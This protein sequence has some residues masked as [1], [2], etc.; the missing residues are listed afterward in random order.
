MTPAPT[1][2]TL[3]PEAVDAVLVRVLGAD[4]V[5]ALSPA[6]RSEVDAYVRQIVT[7][8]RHAASVP[9]V[10]VP[11]DWISTRSRLGAKVAAFPILP[12]ACL[13][14]TAAGGFLDRAALLRT[15]LVSAY[16]D[17]LGVGRRPMVPVG[18]PS[19]GRHYRAPEETVEA[20]TSDGVSWARDRDAV[21][22]LAAL[23]GNTG[24]TKIRGGKGTADVSILFPAEE[25]AVEVGTLLAAPV[26]PLPSGEFRVSL[27]GY[28]ARH[29]LFTVNPDVPDRASEI[30]AAL[31]TATP[32]RAPQE[33]TTRSRRRVLGKAAPRS[34]AAR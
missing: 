34:L 10:V 23:V 31:S 2:S 3:S 32:R 30:R 17:A 4:E 8:C 25:D 5:A 13:A 29:L 20:S 28:R 12:P 7:A 19:S 9:G 27:S 6:A 14:P 1:P 16:V 18:P 15:A 21:T 22:T 11:R 33:G 24:R 26:E